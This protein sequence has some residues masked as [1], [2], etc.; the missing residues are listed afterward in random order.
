MEQKKYLD[1]ERLKEKYALAFTENENIVVQVKIDGANS[2][3]AYDEDEDCLVA[4]SRKKQLTPENTLHGFY[5]FVQGLDL[6]LFKE[7]LGTRYIIFGEFLTPHTI[8]YPEQMYNQFYM[9]DVWDKTK[10]QYILQKE[11]REIF[12]KLNGQIKNY[13]KTLYEGPFIS[14]EHIKNFLNISLYE[15]KPAMEGLVIKSQDRLNNK[16]SRTPAY[17]KIVAEQFSEVHNSK[18]HEVDPEKLKA[19]QAAEALAAT[20]VTE[21]RVTKLIEKAI[22]EGRLKEDWDEKDLRAIAKFLPKEMFA[23]CQKEEAETVSQIEDF[24]KICGGLSMK[25]VR[26]L[27]R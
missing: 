5:D 11:A 15:E 6:Q 2:S 27:I 20:I 3:I 12:K 23:D 18:K 8:T 22:D 13:V 26:G 9:F 24:G 16:S 4:F 7:V 17:V 19:H 25:I 21:R 14:W 1:I 10:E